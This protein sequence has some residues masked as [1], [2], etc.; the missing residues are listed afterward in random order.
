MAT[1]KNPIA[2]LPAS[3]TPSNALLPFLLSVDQVQFQS[4]GNRTSLQR[5]KKFLNHKKDQQPV[6]QA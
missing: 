2:R 6:V 3:V 5:H 1:L 4:T